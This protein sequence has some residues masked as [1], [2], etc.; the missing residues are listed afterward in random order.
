MKRHGLRLAVL[1]A[2][3]LSALSPTTALGGTGG[4][5]GG[6]YVS[7]LPRDLAALDR[8]NSRTASTARVAMFY[9][10]WRGRDGVFDGA[11]MSGIRARGAVPMVSWMPYGI[12]L[13]DVIAGREDAYLRDWFSAARDWGQRL[14]VRPFIEMN[15]D[16]YDWG[17][18]VDGNTP[19]DHIAAW[20]HVVG[21]ARDVGASNIEWVWS[22]NEDES[23]RV[24]LATIYPG[25]KWVDWLGLDGYNWGKAHT[26]GWRSFERIFR[27]SYDEITALSSRPLMIAETAS[28]EDGGNKAAWI[29]RTFTETLPTMPRVRAVIWFH[30]RKEADWRVDSSSRSLAAYRKALEANSAPLP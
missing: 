6:A 15:G 23:R 7:G 26:S 21:L 10:D 17:I 2:V 16:W 29:R 24:S 19:E 30:E 4:V 8:F 1:L 3:A 28:N 22:P 20:R 5:A 11:V 27:S 9:A 14:L 12:S 13:R 18:G 25:D